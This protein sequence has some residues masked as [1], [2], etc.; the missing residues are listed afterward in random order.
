MRKS[1]T[2]C[3]T[4][5]FVK[6]NSLSSVPKEVPKIGGLFLNPCGS[7]V[8]QSCMTSLAPRPRHSKAKGFWDL[9]WRG[10]PKKKKA[11]LRSKTEKYLAFPGTWDRRVY[12]F[13]TMGWMGTTALLTTL[14]SWMNWWDPSGFLIGKIGVV[15]GDSQVIRIPVF[16]YLLTNGLRPSRASG[17]KGY[18][19][20]QG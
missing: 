16:R 4:L 2:Y 18:C 20:F 14:R 19:L 11:F 8:Q 9:G 15:Q 5:L 1:S 10:M 6:V 13:R 17:F 12:R 3:I 7:W